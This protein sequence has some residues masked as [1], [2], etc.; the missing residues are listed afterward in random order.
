VRIAYSAARRRGHSGRRAATHINGFVH[1]ATELGAEV[2]II[3]ND[4]IAGLDE[5]KLAL[6]DPEP[7][8]TTQRLRL[9]NNLIFSAGALREVERSRLIS[10]ISVRRFTWRELRPACALSAI[11]S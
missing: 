3:S 1:G 8:G 10:S 7:V 4:R 9:R 2:T 11:V 6:I 5:T